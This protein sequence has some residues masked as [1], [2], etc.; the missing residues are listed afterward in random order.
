MK[1]E[2]KK[3]LNCIKLV[4]EFKENVNLNFKENKKTYIIFLLGLL[5]GLINSLL[6][7]YWRVLK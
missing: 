1:I 4:K 6:Y 5:L 2:N 3:L 7:I